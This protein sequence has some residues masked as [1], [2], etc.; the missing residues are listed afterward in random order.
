MA[1]QQSNASADDASA[2]NS[3]IKRAQQV[4]ADC[5]K[6]DISIRAKSGEAQIGK[7]APSAPTPQAPSRV[8][9]TLEH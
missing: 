3:P 1:S 6:E 2:G 7:G 5:A 8:S 9:N 4:N